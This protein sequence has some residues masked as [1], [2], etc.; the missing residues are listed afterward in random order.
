MWLNPNWNLFVIPSKKKWTKCLLG[1]ASI[2]FVHAGTDCR[3]EI[4]QTDG[5]ILTLIGLAVTLNLFPTIYIA[6][7]KVLWEFSMSS[8]TACSGYT[9]MESEDTGQQVIRIINYSKWFFIIK[10]WLSKVPCMHI[11]NIITGGIAKVY[12]D[13]MWIIRMYTK[14]STVYWYVCKCTDHIMIVTCTNQYTCKVMNHVI[15]QRRL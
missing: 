6:S 12:S 3:I 13:W 1:W 11:C 14:C 9:T 4:K 5:G 2:S 8:A 15:I 10:G 7:A